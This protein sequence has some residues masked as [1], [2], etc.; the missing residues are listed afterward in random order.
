MDL[1]LFRFVL[2]CR[3]MAREKAWVMDGLL[4]THALERIAEQIVPTV[5]A[6]AKA[7]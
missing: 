1:I 5:G 4:E 6:A 7:I 3:E 2:F